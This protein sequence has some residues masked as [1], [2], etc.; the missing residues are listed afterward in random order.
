MM[1][2][3]W[4]YSSQ[5]GH[6]WSTHNY[7]QHDDH[8][9]IFVG[10]LLYGCTPSKQPCWGWRCHQRD[11]VISTRVRLASGHGEITPS[12]IAEIVIVCFGLV[13]EMAFGMNCA[14]WL[15]VL[16]F[17]SCSITIGIASVVVGPHSAIAW[18]K[19]NGIVRS[20]QWLSYV[21]YYIRST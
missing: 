2:W 15:I 20:S 4:Q 7:Y 13:V 21:L 1:S 19:L 16:L 8:V 9:V 17:A 12:Y 11:V 14:T 18:N 3:N 6:R 5:V 10:G